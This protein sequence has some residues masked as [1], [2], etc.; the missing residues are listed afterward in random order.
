MFYHDNTPPLMNNALLNEHEY[1]MMCIFLTTKN[2]YDQ[3]V[4][5]EDEV[6]R[7]K[8]WEMMYQKKKIIMVMGLSNTLNLYTEQRLQ[9]CMFCDIPLTKTNILEVPCFQLLS[10]FFNGISEM[11]D[12]TF[13]VKNRN[14]TTITADTDTV[15]LWY[16][17]H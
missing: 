11:T 16:V 8:Q 12:V 13:S 2:H 9:V 1:P 4:G 5:E 17:L 15:I 10:S 3:V 6:V 7:V 14:S